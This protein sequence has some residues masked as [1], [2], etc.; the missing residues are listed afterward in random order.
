M[1]YERRLYQRVSVRLDVLWEGA[2]VSDFAEISDIS[3]GGCYV[4]TAAKVSPGEQ[5]TLE[6]LLPRGRNVRLTGEV[7]HL[8]WP[9]GFGV[10]FTG[11]GSE[12]D[13]G[14]LLSLTC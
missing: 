3:L 6:A 7:M 10:R 12:E 5:V 4:R 8:Q 13:Y 14:E 2:A 1:S 11:L 9:V